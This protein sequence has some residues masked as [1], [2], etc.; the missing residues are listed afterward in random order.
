MSFPDIKHPFINTLISQIED[1][2]DIQGDAMT[3]AEQEVYGV[4]WEAFQAPAEAM[5]H[6]ESSNLTEGTSSWLGASEAPPVETMNEVRIDPPTAAL[7]AL[8]SAE[9]LAYL[10]PLSTAEDMEGRALAWD[11]AL[12]FAR[13]L[14]PTF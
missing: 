6:L 13:S 8:E 7:T 9:L 11:H 3:Q 5:S 2:L 12:F 1:V 14:Y 10:G 4:D